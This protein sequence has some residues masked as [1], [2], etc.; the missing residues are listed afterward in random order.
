MT[1]VQAPAGLLTGFSLDD[2][3]RMVPAEIKLGSTKLTIS[4]NGKELLLAAE[5]LLTVEMDFDEEEEWSVVS[6]T[7]RSHTQVLDIKG[8]WIDINDYQPIL[9]KNITARVI[10][11]RINLYEI[12]TDN[13]QS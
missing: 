12:Q 6:P 3:Q 8:D 5:Y 9:D 1:T 7:D 11:D 10:L 13:K 2:L 4:T